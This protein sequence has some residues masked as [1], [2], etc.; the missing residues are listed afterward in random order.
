MGLAVL[1]EKGHSSELDFA[2]ALLPLAL[3]GL[4]HGSHEWFEMALLIYPAFAGNQANQWIP[5]FRIFMLAFSFLMLIAFGARLI[6][7][8]T[9]TSLRWGM[10]FAV[11]SIWIIGLFELII[12]PIPRQIEWSQLMFILAIRWQSLEQ[13]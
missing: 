4:I 9:R 2:Q 1:I 6:S 12:A 7:G 11:V 3:F 5:V 10:L 13:R 8:P